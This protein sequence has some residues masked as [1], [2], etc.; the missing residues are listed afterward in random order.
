MIFNLS[1]AW[2][3]N[4]LIYLPKCVNKPENGCDGRVTTYEYD[5][6]KEFIEAR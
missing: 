1:N 4:A 3:M 2:I 6:A 5:R